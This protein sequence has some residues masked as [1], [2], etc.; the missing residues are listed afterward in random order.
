MC[1]NEAIIETRF[2]QAMRHVYGND[3]GLGEVLF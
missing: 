2:M 1:I 3:R